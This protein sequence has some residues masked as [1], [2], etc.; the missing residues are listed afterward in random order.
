MDKSVKELFEKGRTCYNFSEKPV[1]EALLEDIYNLTKM[2]PT[3]GNCCPLRIIFIQSEE[4]KKRL[5]TCVMEGN[6]AAVDAA[7]VTALFA[8]D[9]RF[10]EKMSF[11]YPT[12][13]SLAD[14]FRTNEAAGQETAFRN[15]TLQAAYFMIAARSKGLDCGP[16]SGFDPIKIESTFLQGTH[17][18]INFICNL[19]YAAGE[20]KYP[21][22]PRIEF[23]DSCSFS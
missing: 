8:Y 4:A 7:P 17:W 2:G 19:G 23:K 5:L 1:T 20:S 11:L 21:R 3:S 12:N 16:M 6:V 22:L 13:P 18:K 15:S 14:F 10:F 9:T